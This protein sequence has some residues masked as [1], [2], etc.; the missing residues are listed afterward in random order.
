[1][2]REAFCLR[3]KCPHCGYY[4]SFPSVT[5][6]YTERLVGVELRVV[7]A[8]QCEACKGYILGIVRTVANPD[9]P[10][11]Y[12]YAYEAHY[13]V[14]RPDD[15]VPEGVPDHIAGDM[16]E[17]MRC[18]WVDA[19]NATVEM[20]RRALEASCVELG[21]DSNLRL[22]EMIDWI[23]SRGKITSPL[24]AMAHKIRLGGNRGAHPANDPADMLD[25]EDADAVIV[26]TKEYLRHVY[27]MPEKMARFDFS[28]RGIS[29]KP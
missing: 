25:A 10:V 6:P 15:S 14:G 18:R 27:E 13:P 12:R 11:E 22:L 1:M 17:A 23:A 19:Y 16:R 7:G 24:Q 29:K 8:A 2:G 28:K 26:F 20:C 21:A 4:A 3:G 5:A 9:S